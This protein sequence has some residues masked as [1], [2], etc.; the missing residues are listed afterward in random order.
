[1]PRLGVYVPAG[2]NPIFLRLF[3]LQL[4]R[5]TRQPDLIAI[6]ENGYSKSALEIAGQDLINQFGDRL[7]TTHDEPAANRIKRYCEPLKTLYYHPAEIETFVK[8]DLD[9]FYYDK[10]IENTEKILEGHDWASHLNNGV[11]LVRPFKGDFKYKKSA[12][13]FLNPVGSAA[14]AVFNRKFAEKYINSMSSQYHKDDV[15]DDDVM[16]ECLKDMDV[17]RAADPIQYVYVSHG[18]NESSYSWQK[19]GGN[20]YLE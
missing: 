12:A 11:L 13:F 9:D 14:L 1:M 8:M 4:A 19:T 6:Y 5:Q 2:P 3:L 16:A 17:Y 10:Y 7:I 18:T 15:A 20:I